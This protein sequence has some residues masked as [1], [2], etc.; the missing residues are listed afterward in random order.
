MRTLLICL[1]ATVIASA[2]HFAMGQESSTDPVAPKSDTTTEAKPSDEP[3]AS[4]KFRVDE[5]KLPPLP[6]PAGL[7]RLAKDYRVWADLKRK[8]VIVDGYICLQRGQLE[9]FACPKKTKEHESIVAIDCPA[10]YIHAGLLLIGAKA[11]QPVQFNPGYAPAMG[12]VIEVIVMWKDKDGK[13]HKVRAQQW[14]RDTST[15]KEMA[16]DWVF[17]GS[18]FYVDP[19]TKVQH[20]FADD[21]D[22]ICVSNFG[23]ATLDLPI[24]ST[25]LSDGLLFECYPDR[26]PPRKT[27]VRLVLRMKDLKKKPAVKQP[28][29]KDAPAVKE[30]P[31]DKEVPT[32]KEVG[33]KKTSPAKTDDPTAESN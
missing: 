20:Y 24:K 13:G 31:A 30:G 6:E 1:V 5:E 21:G 17:G 22:L 16:Y 29:D 7:N 14:I 25:Q 32:D 4:Q 3:P 23:T 26:I 2:T 12:D 11:G 28:A 27:P 15:E 18:G 8:L 9:M 33:E 10:K 19:E